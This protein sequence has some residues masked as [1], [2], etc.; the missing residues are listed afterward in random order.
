MTAHALID[1]ITEEA[2]SN[3]VYRDP[4]IRAMQSVVYGG[5][6]N[7]LVDW[8][9]GRGTGQ[10][11][12]IVIRDSSSC[13]TERVR[14]RRWSGSVLGQQTDERTGRQAADW[15]HLAICRGRGPSARRAARAASNNSDTRK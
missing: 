8:R 2:N 13:Q 6:G 7:L 5:H 3:C 12:D 11:P 15:I 1:V 14:T 10:I 9:R 4:A